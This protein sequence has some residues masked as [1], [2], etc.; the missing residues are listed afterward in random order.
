MSLKIRSFYASPNGE[1]RAQPATVSSLT[2]LASN[3]NQA[4]SPV[5]IAV[6]WPFGCLCMRG[7]TFISDI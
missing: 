6:F 2:I 1:N 5:R 3:L 4:D 7:R